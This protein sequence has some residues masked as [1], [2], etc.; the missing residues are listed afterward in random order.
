M[1]G[2]LG[3]SMDDRTGDQRRLAGLQGLNAL[4]RELLA[5]PT[6]DV[7]LVRLVDAARALVRADF[8]ALLLLREGSSEEVTHFVYDA[9]RDLFPDHLPRVVGLLAVPVVTGRVARID[10]IRGHPAGV[11]IPVEHPPIAALLAAPV[12]LEGRVVG[13]LAVANRVGGRTFDDIDEEVIVELAGHAAIAV[14]LATARQARARLDVTRQALLDVALHNL[15][16]PL[17]V[18]KGFLAT[19]RHHGE[20]LAEDDRTEAF[21]AIERAHERIQELAEGALLD[22]PRRTGEQTPTTEDID[23]AALL[24]ELSDELAGLADGVSLDVSVAPEAPPNF[25]GDRRLVRE[26]L[27]NLVSN[28]MK[29]SR[30]GQTVKVMARGEGAAVRFDVTDRGPGIAPEEQ[31][32]VFEQFYRTQQSVEGAVPGTGLGLWIARRLAELQ[33]GAVG[34]SSR[35]GHGTTSWATLPLVPPAAARDGIDARSSGSGPAP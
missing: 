28:A 5:E 24:R 20:R 33:G 27:D 12:L 35:T 25:T 34:V 32:L 8:S 29:H 11:G 4:A 23:I 1:N 15:R 6:L 7:L 21:E 10:D 16:T 2:P 17:T 18:A 14:S 22:D 31:G 13:E 9:P 26:L 30:P 19:I 3:A